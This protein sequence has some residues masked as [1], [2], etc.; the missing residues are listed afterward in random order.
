MGIPTKYGEWCL[1][2]AKQQLANLLNN[3]INLILN[4]NYNVV[5]K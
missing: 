3:I 5:Q 1:K 4:L 2:T